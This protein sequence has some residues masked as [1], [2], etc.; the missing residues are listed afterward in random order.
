MRKKVLVVFGGLF[1]LLGFG[2]CA[3]PGSGTGT[4]TLPDRLIIDTYDPITV[5]PI[6]DPAPGQ[7]GYPVDAANASVVADLFEAGNLVTP[8]AT[9]D[10]VAV[11]PG[12]WVNGS[13]IPA[14][15]GFAYIDYPAPHAGD[16]FVRV[17]LGSPGPQAYALRV[18]GAAS[19]DYAT[20]IFTSGDVP[21]S[22]MN[23]DSASASSI[24]LNGRAVRLLAGTHESWFKI[25]LP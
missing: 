11:R 8:L 4:G 18:L 25:T 23:Q 2:A 15:Q 24:S 9:N 1:L 14:Y 12:T 20:W 17:H 19:T 16:Y 3:A 6:A 13:S 21:G 5:G 10:G 22:S 7:G